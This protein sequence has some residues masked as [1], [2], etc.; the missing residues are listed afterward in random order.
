VIE[1]GDKASGGDRTVWW[2]AGAILV[3]SVAYES[4]FVTKGLNLMD[5]AWPL[6]AARQVAEG[7][8]LYADVLFVFPPGHLIPAWIGLA[9]DPP[10]VVL[11]RAIYA[12]F[13]VALAVSIYFLARRL[14]PPRFAL[15][16]AACVALAAPN[17]HL[18]HTI[19]G[20]RYMVFSVLALL[21]FQRRLDTGRLAWLGVAGVL[22]GV[23]AFF[24]LGPAFAAGCGI[25]VAIAVVQK[26]LRSVARDWAWLGAGV[27]AVF[28]PLL[29]WCMAT[30]GVPGLWQEIVTR[31]ATMLVLQSLPLPPIEWP[32][33]FDRIDIRKLFVAL[34]FRL[35]WVLYVAYGAGLAVA[36]VN[37]RRR[38][39]PFAHGLLVAVWVW[40]AV[41][42]SRS[43]TRSDEPHLDSVIPPVVVLVTHLSWL[44]YRRIAAWAGIT[45]GRA[46]GSELAFTTLFVVTW[47][48]LLGTDLW[49]PE[50]R[51]GTHPV[52]S[53]DGRVEVHNPSQAQLT[54][55]IVRRLRLTDPDARILD[56]TASPLYKHLADRRGYGRN[57]LVMP[58]TFL[59]PDEARAFLDRLRRDPPALVIWPK[60]PFDRDPGRSLE[61]TFPALAAF[62]EHHYVRWGL[63]RR[64]Y[65]MG[66]RNAE[67]PEGW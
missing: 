19:F 59:S 58:G 1:Q 25:G 61:L 66:P 30:V 43:V 48:L 17:S 55:R 29:V 27:L 8:A 24:R 50:S 4:L 22:L 39:A 20:Y 51:R 26:D 52:A 62:V 6:W 47:V 34:Q 45:G 15:A 42:F 14:V 11:A 21:A 44:V 56:L 7:G 16:G 37:A 13:A 64:H 54:D 3:L 36:F 67:T 57:D 38:R 18:M 28:V 49:L 31:P 9:L 5:E 33:T 53:L 32:D 40:G 63:E 2:H 12:A 35:V 23:G 60:R 46:I 41:F 65:L 10:G